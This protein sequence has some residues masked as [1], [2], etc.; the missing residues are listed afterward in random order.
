MY[1]RNIS[2][3]IGIF[4]Y[5][6]ELYYFLRAIIGRVLID[7]IVNQF[8]IVRMNREAGSVSNNDI[9]FA[10]T[11]VSR[12]Q[13]VPHTLSIK[14]RSQIRLEAN[15]V[16]QCRKQVVN[17]HRLIAANPG[18]YFTRPTNDCRHTRTTFI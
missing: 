8:E 5:F 4:V 18:G 9:R 11:G 16:H 6:E 7:I 15:R 12:L 2:C 14:G 10:R 1:V 17:Y 13:C 3:F